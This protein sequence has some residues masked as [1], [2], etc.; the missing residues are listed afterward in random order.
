MIEL[1]FKIDI[2]Q[3]FSETGF[4]PEWNILRITNLTLSENLLNGG[5]ILD[6][7]TG[8]IKIDVVY[9]IYMQRNG[10]FIRTISIPPFYGQYFV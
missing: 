9:R 6:E 5:T 4:R 1:T 10:S 2:E 3:K 7:E 8:S